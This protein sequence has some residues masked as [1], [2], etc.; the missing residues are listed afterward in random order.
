MNN[1]EILRERVRTMSSPTFRSCDLKDIPTF[2]AIITKMVHNGELLVVSNVRPKVY[3]KHKLK[4]YKPKTRSRRTREE[5][6]PLYA[7]LWSEVYPEYFRIPDFSGY[8]STVRG[9][10]IDL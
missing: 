8:R 10:R 9:S 6:V 5:V 7:Q 1:T 4:D 2:G 3:K